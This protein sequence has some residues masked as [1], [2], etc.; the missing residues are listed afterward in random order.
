M[1]SLTISSK[2]LVPFSRD[3]FRSASLVSRQRTSAIYHDYASVTFTPTHVANHLVCIPLTGCIRFCQTEF[4][5]HC[6]PAS[7]TVVV[8][9]R[10]RV[11]LS[12]LRLGDQV[13][14]LHRNSSWPSSGKA[15]D[16]SI[17]FEP[18]L[19]HTCIIF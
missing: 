1:S 5:I 9:D 3:C 8:R 17:R 11:P 13:L 7:S 14:V 4:Q 10:G 2:W 16:W 19:L 15:C 18:V 12:S 6:F